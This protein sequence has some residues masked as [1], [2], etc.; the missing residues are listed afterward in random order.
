MSEEILSEIDTEDLTQMP[1]SQIRQAQYRDGDLRP[2]IQAVRS[3]VKPACSSGSK[4][5][6]SFSRQFDRLKLVRGVLY[7]ETTIQDETRLQLVLPSEWINRVLHMLHN[8]VGHPGRDR[9]ISLI[10]DRFFW[11]RMAGDVENWVRTAAGCVRFKTQ[12]SHRAP[13]VNIQTTQPLEL[14]CMD[15]LQLDVAKGGIQYVLVI[16]DHFTRYAMAIPTRNMT[17]KTTADA[18]MNNFVRHY[19]LQGLQNRRNIWL[20]TGQPAWKIWLPNIFYWLPNIF[21]YNFDRKHSAKSR[22]KSILFHT[23]IQ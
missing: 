16:T 14:V 2:W 10:R 20:P 9:T 7:R 3:G 8:D 11:P 1:V 13:L 23:K 5:H 4:S 18:F 15:F 17:A 22:S 12:G 6:L 21:S 19:G